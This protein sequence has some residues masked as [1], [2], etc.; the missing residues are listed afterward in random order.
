MSLILLG[1]AGLSVHVPLTVT[2]E[3]QK[4]TSN[5]TSMLPASA[6][7]INTNILLSEQVQWPSPKSRVRD[8]HSA[9]QEAMSG[10]GCIY[11]CR[12]KKMGLM[13]KSC[14]GAV[15]L[16]ILKMRTPG[17]VRRLARCPTNVK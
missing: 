13:T 6:C 4:V 3:V 10:H 11:Y 8:V 9:H 17:E 16:L 1:P 12:E 5:L 7:L 14:M 15:I 2:A